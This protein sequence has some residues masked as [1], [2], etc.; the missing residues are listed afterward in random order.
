MKNKWEH[1]AGQWKQ[2][3]GEIK[4]KWSELTDAELT[5]IKGNRNNLATLLQKRYQ[6]T[7]KDANHQIDMWV[8]TLKV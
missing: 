3:S 6:I 7:K 5:E 4:K 2:Y 8:N 1:V